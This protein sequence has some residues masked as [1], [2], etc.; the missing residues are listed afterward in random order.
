MPTANTTLTAGP[1]SATTI[2]CRDPRASAPGGPRRRWARALCRAC[3]CRSAGRSVRDPSSCRTTIPNKAKMKIR[4]P[5]ASPKSPW[6][7]SAQGHPAE[8]KEKRGMDVDVD[9]RN[10]ANPP[11]PVHC[12]SPNSP[13]G[14]V[15][16]VPRST[17]FPV[18]QVGPPERPG[19]GCSKWRGFDRY[20]TLAWRR[21]GWGYS[22]MSCMT[23]SGMAEL[24]GSF[25]CC[26]T[27]NVIG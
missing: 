7:Q 25:N 11:G 16:F 14:W 6:P 17:A 3:G 9:P 4:P 27:S 19:P 2:S 10:T 24:T 5:I 12:C 26:A 21:M 13:C 15:A 1:A 20:S 8:Y 23:W 18:I 22:P